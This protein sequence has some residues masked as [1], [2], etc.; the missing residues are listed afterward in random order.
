MLV[1]TCVDVAV[2]HEKNA[3][4]TRNSIFFNEGGARHE[5]YWEHGGDLI[6]NEPR[7]ADFALIAVLPYLMNRGSDVRILGNV[8]R[9]LM[10]AAEECIDVWSLWRPDRFRRVRVSA[11]DLVSDRAPAGREGVL[12]FSGGVDSTFA[13]LANQT[14]LL[15]HRSRK[16]K[17]GV[18]IHG[19]DIPIS[20]PELFAMSCEHARHILADIGVS[21][22]TVRT[23]WRE[24]C[25]D[26]EMSHGFGVAAVLHQ[27]HGTVPCGIFAAD[28]A[29]GDEEHPWGN[30]SVTN[31]LLS[32]I[33]FPIYT[34]GG[35]YTR[36][37][38]VQE[39]ARSGPVRG[40]IRVC[41]EN[42]GSGL[43]CGICE[44]C[45]RT[46]LM[47]FLAGHAEIPAFA[48]PLNP[49]LLS[50]IRVTSEVNRNYLLSILND[51]RALSLD[52]EVR[53]ALRRVTRKGKGKGMRTII[54]AIARKVRS[55]L[56]GVR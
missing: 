6:P 24:D 54:G 12:A 31:P 41:W 47:F 7:V 44:K 43:N 40:H 48:V 4:T 32:G 20:R 9:S 34:C 37:S 21:L 50:R 53:R 46:R 33:S 23:N 8:T 19:F 16:V 30:S 18:L 1:M 45:V 56:S 36:I 13:L 51:P 3:N 26:W 10:E 14:G 29:Y 22:S 52:S 17:A 25:V 38:K 39:I 55:A 2:R 42:L 35:G 15:G 28:D 27:Y 5:I 49:D 11:T